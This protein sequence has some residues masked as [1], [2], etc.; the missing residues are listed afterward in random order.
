MRTSVVAFIF[1]VAVAAAP[2]PEVLAKRAA[3]VTR[4]IAGLEL[5]SPAPTIKAMAFTTLIQRGYRGP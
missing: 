4:G 2:A 3:L 5:S 1:V